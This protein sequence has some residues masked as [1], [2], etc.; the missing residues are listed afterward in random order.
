MDKKPLISIITINFNDKIGLQRTFDSVFAQDYQDF[1]YIVIDG[2]SNDGSKELIEENTDKISYWISEPD[3]G[4]YNAMNK[5]I[6]VANGEYLLF[7]NSGDH[8]YN[9]QVLENNYIYI[10]ESDLVLFDIELVNE[11]LEKSIQTYPK[12]L[13][14]STFFRGTI[15]HPTTFI[16][17]ELF[18]KIGLYDETL[19]IVSDWKF[20]MQ[21]VCSYNCTFKKIN[22]VLSTFYL[23]GIS[24]TSI[25][26]IGIER[27]RVLVENYAAFI[28]DMYYLSEVKY[29]FD[30]LEKFKI[31]TLLRKLRL[32]KYTK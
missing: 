4:I 32:V 19:K 6:K 9:N 5:G 16:K 13:K 27:K 20:F 30:K 15:G 28:D 21:A 14:F 22:N 18:G 11:L 1:E 17:K 2:G 29:I 26:E 3:K 25:E 7:L 10:K 8:L 12:E 23:D 31:I 24:S